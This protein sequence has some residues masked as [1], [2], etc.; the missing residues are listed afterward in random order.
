MKEVFQ[1]KLIN[2]QCLTDGI[3]PPHITC[4]IRSVSTLANVPSL[5]TFCIPSIRPLVANYS[6]GRLHQGATLDFLANSLLV[7]S[8]QAIVNSVSVMFN[9]LAEAV[10]RLPSRVQLVLAE[11][12][13]YPPMNHKMLRSQLFSTLRNKLYSKGLLSVPFTN[14]FFTPYKS[15]LRSDCHFYIALL[16]NYV[17][18]QQRIRTPFP[19]SLR[20]ALQEDC[21]AL[22]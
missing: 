14:L 12:C 19:I 3:E 16:R 21:C 22:T 2:S 6:F 18:R 10:G 8:L 5:T 7:A 1:N 17:R 15:T 11:D 20:Q 13:Y 9:L 4:P